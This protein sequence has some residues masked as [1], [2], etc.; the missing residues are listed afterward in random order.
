[1]W[2]SK[3]MISPI[4]NLKDQSL[5]GIPQGPKTLITVVEKNKK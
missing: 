2:L 1:M 5:I 3:L 4:V